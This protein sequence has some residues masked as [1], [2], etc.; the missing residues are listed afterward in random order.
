MSTNGK[1]PHT[2]AARL[3]GFELLRLTFDLGMSHTALEERRR[4]G[5]PSPALIAIEGWSEAV[6]GDA[7]ALPLT[8]AALDGM[9]YILAWYFR[10]D[11]ALID[12]L[13]DE[14]ETRRPFLRRT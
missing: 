6:G 8:D 9:P 7:P 3:P 14:R 11:D 13:V 1:H 2:L 12:A 4:A 5:Q 10:T